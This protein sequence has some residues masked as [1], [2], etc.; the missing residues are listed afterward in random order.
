MSNTK[1]NKIEKIIS[2][3]L[4]VVAIVIISL[5]GMILLKMETAD[6]SVIMKPEKEYIEVDAHKTEQQNVLININTAPPEELVLLPGIGENKAKAIVAY[7]EQTPFTTKEE[8]M[9]VKGIG[10]SIFAEI[11]DKICVE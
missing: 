6:H 1:Q 5:V 9:N 3:S 11:A 4:S 8:I 10:E 7:R 2:V